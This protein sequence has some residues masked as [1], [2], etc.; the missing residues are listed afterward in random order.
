[1]EVIGWEIIVIV[2]HSYFSCLFLLI[3]FVIVLLGHELVQDLPIV[4]QLLQ[5]IAI[6]SSYSYRDF[7]F[8]SSRQG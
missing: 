6:C 3:Y 8:V 4:P 5:L 2:L 1:L 7:D